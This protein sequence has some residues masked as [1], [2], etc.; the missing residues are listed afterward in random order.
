[1]TGRAITGMAFYGLVCAGALLALAVQGC[2]AQPAVV[3]GAVA[4]VLM[5]LGGMFLVGVVVVALV[6]R[7]WRARRVVSDARTPPPTM[8]NTGAAAPTPPHESTAPQWRTGNTGKVPRILLALITTAMAL[9][10][11][12]GSEGAAFAAGVVATALVGAFLLWCE[13]LARIRAEGRGEKYHTEMRAAEAG[14]AYFR[15][16]AVEAGALPP[17]PTARPS[18][19]DGRCICG[20]RI[21]ERKQAHRQNCPCF[22]N[23]DADWAVRSW[24]ASATPL[25]RRPPVRPFLALLALTLL[26][27]AGCGS[28][29]PVALRGAA[30]DALGCGLRATQQV[31]LPLAGEALD[32]LITAPTAEDADVRLNALDVRQ[33]ALTGVSGA[34]TCVVAHLLF[35]VLGAPGDLLASAGDV[36][37]GT[38]RPSSV[39]RARAIRYLGA[40]VAAPVGMLR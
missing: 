12:T 22:T 30:S 32:A 36:I 29:L 21:V 13:R 4:A 38:S 34:V 6:G 31:M 37:A 16:V 14:S 7:R 17:L 18:P 10:G 23:E 9:P 35:D 39:V 28:L 33:R 1:M 3:V 2:H 15:Q 40:R 26:P 11:C 25:R 19:P 24:T 5:L 8:G 27:G 20:P